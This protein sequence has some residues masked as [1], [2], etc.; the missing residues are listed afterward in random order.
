MTSQN[1]KFQT[2]WLIYWLRSAHTIDVSSFKTH[3]LSW[4]LPQQWAS[5]S[6]DRQPTQTDTDTPVSSP[7]PVIMWRRENHW[8]NRHDVGGYSCYWWLVTGDHD[9]VEGLSSVH[10]TVASDWTQADGTG[11]AP[12]TRHILWLIE[13]PPIE[14]C[15]IIFMSAHCCY[16]QLQH[17]RNE[18]RLSQP[19]GHS[20]RQ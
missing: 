5:P 17:I 1:S 10:I 19:H 16:N 15:I 20:I 7:C 2:S 14:V 18:N 12:S 8:E 11:T 3:L 13:D 6:W 9:E 4:N